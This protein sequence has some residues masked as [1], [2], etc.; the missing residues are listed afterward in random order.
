MPDTIDLRKWSIDSLR[1]LVIAPFTE[2]LIYR[3]SLIPYLL[4]LG[5]KPVHVVFVAPV[6]FGF[7]HVHHAYNQIK[8]GHR[9]KEVLLVTAFQF[10]YTSLFGAYATYACLVWG[11]VLGVVFIHSFCN[12]MGLPSFTFMQRGDRVYEKRWI[13][14]VAFI[15]GLVGFISLFWIFEMK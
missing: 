13:V 15:V 4:Q 2:E 7:A 12:F 5:Y 10:T 1:N 9:M 14:M 8:Q 11:D 6:F 3:S